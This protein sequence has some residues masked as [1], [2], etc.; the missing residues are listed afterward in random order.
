[1]IMAFFLCN[2]L[3]D[4]LIR[5]VILSIVWLENR[6][7]YNKLRRFKEGV[8]F[9]QILTMSYLK[10]HVNTYQK[11]FS[12]WYSYK[13]AFAIVSSLLTVILIVVQICFH[14]EAMLEVINGVVLIPSVIIALV[15]CLQF[16]INRNTKYDRI[17]I[18]RKK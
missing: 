12:V 2:A 8:G 14:N 15:L 5:E 16:D 9:Q 4:W 18:A 13:K 6:G 17:R 7:K 10:E 3:S 11:E 1:M